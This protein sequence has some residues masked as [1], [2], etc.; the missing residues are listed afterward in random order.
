MGRHAYL[1]MAHKNDYTFHTLLKLLDDKRN[2]L[3]IHMDKKVK[4]Y[5]PVTVQSNVAQ[6]E[7][8]HTPQ[9]WDI[10]WGGD[11]QIF[12]ELMLL[13]TA[14][15]KGKYDYY[16]LISGEDLPIKTQNSIHDFF[17]MYSG[18][19][20]FELIEGDYLYRVQYY[21][22][23]QNKLGKKDGGLISR[24][25][26]LCI[27]LQ[28]MMGIHRNKGIPLAKGSNWFSITDECANYILSQSDQIRRIFHSS[29][30]AD[31]LFLQSILL[32]TEFV[33]NRYQSEDGIYSIQRYI[34]WTDV[35]SASPK[36]FTIEDYD[37]LA[38]SKDIFARKF[39][40]KI[41]RDIIKFVAENLAVSK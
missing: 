20:F 41:D 5:D 36:I 27:R 40:C 7:V 24:A 33:E 39:D 29:F 12:L 9:R 26:G 3:F 23:F 8:I 4:D 30:C 2:T 35:K 31:E 38:T 22:L 28:N 1:I 14:V 6:A 19:E 21:H 16:H 25:N 10:R 15:S 18:K 34:D 32:G 37:R 11:K 13:Q 17:D